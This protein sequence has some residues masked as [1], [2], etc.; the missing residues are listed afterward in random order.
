MKRSYL[1]YPYKIETDR[2][3]L[4]FPRIEEADIINEAT[5]ESLAELQRWLPWAKKAP[6]IDETDAFNRATIGQFVKGTDFVFRL[7]RRADGQLVGLVGLHGRDH[8]VP[9]FETGYWCRT[10]FAGRGYISEGVA[11]VVELARSKLGARRV[12]IRVDERNERS[13][14]IPER[15]GFE[16]EGGHRNYGRDNQGELFDMRCY[17]MAF[18]D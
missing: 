5:I 13:W 12:Q 16:L 14:R 1:P 2:L 6:S 9:S 4:R 8:E 18:D 15:L 7:Y 11:A 10:K 17:A 3:E